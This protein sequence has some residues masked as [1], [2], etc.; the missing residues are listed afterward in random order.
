MTYNYAQLE[1]LWD[2]AGGPANQAS[3]AAGIAEAESGG[4]PVAAY[5][6]T[7]VQPGQG[8]TTD[9]TGLWQIL[10][11]P[12]GNFTAAE[13]TIPLDNA[14]MAVA[15]YQQAGNS[16]SP[17]QTYDQGSVQVQNGVAPASSVP[18]ANSQGGSGPSV[19]T[20]AGGS[21]ASTTPTSTGGNILTNTA[22]SA[23]ESLLAAF[24]ITPTS[25]EDM[26]E[27]LGL[28][29]VGLIAIFMGIKIFTSTSITT[30]PSAVSKQ[31]KSHP[32]E[33]A[34]AAEVAEVAA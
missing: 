11:L 2:Q 10:G 19:A 25:I 14:K 22:V 15:K 33:A 13:L 20:P 34:D 4:N 32:S 3:E 23:F 9:A 18:G 26:L 21:P 17:W 16:F 27:R 29:I 24:G 8:S 12:A 1:A 28:M 7:T 30:S 5:P 31:F 6:G